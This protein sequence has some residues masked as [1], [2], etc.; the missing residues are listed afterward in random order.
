MFSADI[1]KIFERRKIKVARRTVAKYRKILKIP[2]SSTRSRQ[3]KE[4]SK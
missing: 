4:N 2:S 1:S 3:Y